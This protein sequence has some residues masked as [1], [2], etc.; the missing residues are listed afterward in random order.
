MTIVNSKGLKLSYKSSYG[1]LVA[2]VVAKDGDDTRTGFK[3]VI[4]QDMQ[5]LDPEVV[6]KEAC[7]N[8]LNALHGTQCNE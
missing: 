7:D 3:Y 6:V 8:A 5:A 2:S 4:G 1:V